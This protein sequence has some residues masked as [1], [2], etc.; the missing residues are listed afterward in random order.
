MRS[1]FFA[2]SPPLCILGKIYFSESAAIQICYLLHVPTDARIWLCTPAIE[3]P[4]PSNGGRPQTK[5][6][7]VT[8][9]PHPEVRQVAEEV[10]RGAWR[11]NT[12]N[13]AS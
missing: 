13:K 5:P 6:R 11:Q 3:S 7:V 9:V 10:L 8:Q 1:F 2:R 12:I 4:G